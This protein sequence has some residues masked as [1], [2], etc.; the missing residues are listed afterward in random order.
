FIGS[1]KGSRNQ[2]KLSLHD[3]LPICILSGRDCRDGSVRT[4]QRRSAPQ[5]CR[6][7]A[8][9]A[10]PHRATCVFPERSER[11]A[12][13]ERQVSHVLPVRERKSTRINSSHVTIS[14]AGFHLK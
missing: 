9:A 10:I 4:G 12:F 7:P 5:D 6:R 3:A 2:K 14:S 13:L 1:Q 11:A 8:S